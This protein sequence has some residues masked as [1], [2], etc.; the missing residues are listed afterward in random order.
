M[1][2][3][4]QSPRGRSDYVL[5]SS[6]S[7]SMRLSMAFRMAIMLPSSS[8]FSARV[9][10]A[11]NRSSSGLQRLRLR[12][13]ITSSARGGGKAGGFGPRAGS[14]KLLVCAFFVNPGTFGR[15]AEAVAVLGTSAEPPPPPPAF[16]DHTQGK[17]RSGHAA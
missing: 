2:S 11:S 6:S 16:P 5:P 1:E 15:L 13:L 8:S 3:R 12:L 4:T 14:K 7:S 9:S 10:M 17:R